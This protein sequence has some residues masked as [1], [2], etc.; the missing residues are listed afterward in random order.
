MSLVEFLRSSAYDIMDDHV[1]NVYTY[2]DKELSKLSQHL[3]NSQDRVE[4]VVADARYDIQKF[5]DKNQ[6]DEQFI[7]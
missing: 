4:R 3:Y 7:K 1:S 6:F 2:I 5:F